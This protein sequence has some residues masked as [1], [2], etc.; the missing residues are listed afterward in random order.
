[1]RRAVGGQAN[2]EKQ[3]EWGEVVGQDV[4]NRCWQRN[5]DKEKTK[6]GALEYY[7]QKHEMQKE[8]MR[9]GADKHRSMIEK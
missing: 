7:K 6:C 1:M 2:E 8:M 4:E 3:L 9:T 5:R